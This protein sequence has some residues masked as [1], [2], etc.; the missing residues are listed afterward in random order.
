[1]KHSEETK[2]KMSESHMG[3][4]NGRWVDGRKKEVPYPREWTQNL[5]DRVRGRQDYTCA[6]CKTRVGRGHD[7]NVHH[8]DFDKT[9]C[10]F[11][12]LAAL[13]NECH[14]LAHR[15]DREE[16]IRAQLYAYTA[17]RDR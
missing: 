17:Q 10:K 7:M 6:L 2:R 14:G 5:R 12:N 11:Y 16:E 13:C 3:E 1:M 9:N 8:I 4:K 15:R